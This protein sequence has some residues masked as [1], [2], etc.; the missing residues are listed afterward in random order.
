MDVYLGTASVERS[1]DPTVPLM[2][3]KMA[4]LMERLKA[5][6]KVDMKVDIK[7]ETKVGKEVEL[8]AEQL[9]EQFAEQWA[10]LSVGDMAGMM[11]LLT[12]E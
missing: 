10:A 3:I 2:E 5:V 12:A 1:T 7:V 4:V 11:E 6:S 9:A 8:L